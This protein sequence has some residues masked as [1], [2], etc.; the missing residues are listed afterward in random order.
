MRYDPE[1]AVPRI[2][3]LF[4]KY[5][6]PLTFFVPGWTINNYPDAIE[7]MLKNS[8]EIEHHGYLHH[9]NNAMS[10]QQELDILRH[11]IELIERVSGRRPLGYRTPMISSNGVSKH[12]IDLLIEEGF[13]YDTSL[14][15]DDIPYILQNNKGLLV[16]IPCFQ[17]L[18]D[19]YHYMSWS[20][21]N[22][23][24]AVS[25]PAR[26]GEVF[27]AEFDA[28]WEHRGMWMCV[29]HPFVSG[30]LA[31]CAAI[32]PLIKY[33]IDKGDVWFASMSEI[34][35]HVKAVI[36][37]GEWTPRIDLMPYY[38]S[39]APGVKFGGPIS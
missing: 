7:L 13:L 4:K 20:D 29:W 1:I 12:T 35:E 26:A 11:G 39:P 33:M 32:E 14:Y 23:R 36:A 25:S 18:G 16:E 10:R 34:A 31:R 3:D 38:V 37:S 2:I 27:K 17:G 8:H 9:D 5:K 15:G 22:Y 24:G 6:I 19:W 30:R 21:F 28:A